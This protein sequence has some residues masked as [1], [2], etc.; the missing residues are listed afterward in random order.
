MRFA[1][2]TTVFGNPADVTLAGLAIEA[3]FLADHASAWALTQHLLA[4]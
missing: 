1:S 4:D 2:T 3:F